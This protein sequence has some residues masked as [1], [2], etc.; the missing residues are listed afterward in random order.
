MPIEPTYLKTC[1]GTLE[2]FNQGKGPCLVFIHG[3]EGQRGWLRYHSYLSQSFNVW[4]PTLPG[5]G[6]S[7]IPDWVQSVP[8]ISKMLL[9]ALNEAGISSCIIGGASLGGWIAAEMASMDPDRFSA[10]ILCASQGLPTGHLDTP[11]IFLTPYR[12]YIGLG[13]ANTDTDSF[14]SDWPEDIDD[15]AIELDLETME[16]VARLAFKPYMYDRALLSSI[17]RFN[18]PKLLIWGDKDNITPLIIAEKFKSNLSDSHLEIIKNTGHYIH[19]EKPKEFA[20]T[21][22]SYNKTHLKVYSHG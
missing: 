6:S 22:I 3:E 11:D 8:H 20:D 12:R 13:Y 2:F 19:L 14:R 21:I 10:L 9:E 5:I 18:K 4:A 17:K 1:F 16:L 15:E 7:E